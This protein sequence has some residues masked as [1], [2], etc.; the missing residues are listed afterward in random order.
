MFI[1]FINYFLQLVVLKRVG[2]ESTGASWGQVGPHVHH[3][4]SFPLQGDHIKALPHQVV[5]RYGGS[6]LTLDVVPNPTGEGR[7]V[8]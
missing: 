4:G 3:I 1:L 8:V 5:A 7:R 6:R 2:A